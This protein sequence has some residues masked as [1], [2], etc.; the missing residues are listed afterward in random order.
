MFP[1]KKMRDQILIHMPFYS[2]VSQ[3][4]AINR[5]YP[6]YVKARK[7]KVDTASS[8]L[9]GDRPHYSPTNNTIHL[10]ESP[11]LQYYISELSHAVQFARPG[12]WKEVVKDVVTHPIEYFKNQRREENSDVYKR[13]GSV[14]YNAHSVIEPEIRQ[15]V[16]NE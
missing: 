4:D 16:F 3:V 7:P 5:L 11:R 1:D 15:V 13:K 10:G 8:I 14:E 2:K 6:F 9:V 12:Q